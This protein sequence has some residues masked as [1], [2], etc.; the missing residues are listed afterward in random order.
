MR[1]S[2]RRWWR[3]WCTGEGETLTSIARTEGVTDRFVARVVAFAFL[4]PDLTAQI[5]DGQQSPALSTDDLFKQ[6]LLPPSWDEQRQL[7]G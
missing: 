5:L 4:A 7:L 1:P 6:W 3:R 2:W